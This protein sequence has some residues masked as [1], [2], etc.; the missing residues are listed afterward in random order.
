ML[1]TKS[2]VTRIKNASDG[3]TNRLDT[4]RNELEDVSREIMK[5][6]RIAE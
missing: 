1:E 4:P 6:I 5:I 3:R 2:T